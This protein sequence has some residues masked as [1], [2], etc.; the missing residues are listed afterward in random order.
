[1]PEL[2]GRLFEVK[3]GKDQK[4]F[5]EPTSGRQFRVLF[6]VLMDWGGHHSYLDLSIFNLSRETEHKMLKRGEVVTL[7]GGYENRF[8]NLFQGEISNVLPERFGADRITRI[9]AK[10][11]A[12]ALQG[13]SI[14][15]TLGEGSALRDAVKACADAMGL[16]AVINGQE[17]EANLSNGQTLFGDPKKILTQLSKT[18]GFDWLIENSKLVAVGSSANRSGSVHQITPMT[19]MEGSPE[20]EVSGTSDLMV[21]VKTRLNPK[22]KI[23]QLFKIE[24]AYPQ[25]N[26]S[27]AYYDRIPETAGTGTYKTMLIEHAGDS[28]GDTWTTKLKGLKR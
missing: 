6:R 8:D 25:A 17:F 28:Y 9:F 15:R 11:G 18:H 19:G 24:S 26:F 23:G 22:V 7:A 27:N 13:A 21:N 12:T 4:T 20:I 14:T 16:P 10:G 3:L 1:M 5:I 2:Y